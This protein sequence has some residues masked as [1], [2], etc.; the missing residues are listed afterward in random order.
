MWSS[1]LDSWRKIKVDGNFILNWPVC[2]VIVNG[3]AYWVVKDEI[4]TGNK[5]LV[6][7]FDMST[8]VLQLV[9]LPEH[10]L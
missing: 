2:D 7:S 4:K 6:V 9:S 3:V 5:T 8:E 1:N 10:L